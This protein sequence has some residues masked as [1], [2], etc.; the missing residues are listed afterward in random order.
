VASNHRYL[1]IVSCSQRK[2]SDTDLLPAIERYDGGNFRLL[3]KAKREGHLPQSL[4]V[5][6]LSAKYG[7]IASTTSIANYE[8]RMNRERASE[9]NVQT[10]QTLRSYAQQNAYQEVYIELGQ[11][12]Y[13]AIGNLNEIFENSTVIYAQGRIG[14]RL[15]SLKQWLMAKCK[16]DST[17]LEHSR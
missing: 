5:L 11:D 8:Q 15:A 12:Y 3:R 6:I 10:R 2:R 4:D 9:L 1:L 17:I 16:S 7:L 14:E 13:Y